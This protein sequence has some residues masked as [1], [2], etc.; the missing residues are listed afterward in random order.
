MKDLFLALEQLGV[1]E[2]ELRN[3]RDDMEL[4]EDRVS[5]IAKVGL[6]NRDQARRLVEEHAAPIDEIRYPLV[7]FTEVPSQTNLAP[8]LEG[9]S[10]AA[11]NLLK[12]LIDAAVAM[13]KKIMAWIRNTFIDYVQKLRGDITVRKAM[14]KNTMGIVNV[15]SNYESFIHGQ[16]RFT[17]DTQA[18]T[19]VQERNEAVLSSMNA[20][21]AA[22]LDQSSVSADVFWLM[23]AEPTL[24]AEIK[25]YFKQVQ[26]ALSQLEKAPASAE[27][28][29]KLQELAKP[30]IPL[31]LGYALKHVKEYDQGS[32][33]IAELLGWIR[34]KQD[35]LTV[36]TGEFK[37]VLSL[38]KGISRLGQSFYADG[39]WDAVEFGKRAGEISDQANRILSQISDV[40]RRM[41]PQQ[42]IADLTIQ[43]ASFSKVMTILPLIFLTHRRS[44]NQLANMVRAILLNLKKYY[45]DAPAELD[46]VVLKRY[47]SYFDGLNRELGALLNVISGIDDTPIG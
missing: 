30:Y 5:E 46:A 12:K 42:G 23:A 35:E 16:G 22:I 26:E 32:R 13:Y 19:Q 27:G 20:Y 47:R 14:A 25:L 43:V 21:Q 31:S 29:S 4:L 41:E 40:S 33:N 6:I 7:S 34:A 11:R 38:T 39:V 18:G 37:D 3:V 8:A 10:D 9:A 44:L 1:D 17:Q 15:C 36:Q 2:E 24:C 45:S 28:L